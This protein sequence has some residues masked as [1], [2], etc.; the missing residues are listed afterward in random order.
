M[1]FD[2]ARKASLK[3]KKRE[4]KEKEGAV[5]ATAPN[6]LFHNSERLF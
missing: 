2:T 1:T 4:K 6:T 5:G 3:K